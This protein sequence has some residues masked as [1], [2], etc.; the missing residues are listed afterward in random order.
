MQQS[1]SRSANPG[2]FRRALLPYMLILPV[3]AWLVALT[4]FPFVK[5]LQYSFLGWVLTRPWHKPFVGFQN[6]ASVL[7]PRNNIFWNAMANTGLFVAGALSVELVLG[8]WLASLVSRPIKAQKFFVTT[9]L[10]PMVISP[11]VAG[12]FYRAAF[13]PE[14]GLIN[15]FIKAIGLVHLAPQEGFLGN[16]RTALLA[17]ISVDIWQWTP[18]TFLILFA[19]IRSLPNEPFEAAEIDGSS[20]MQRF[21]Y[22]TLPLL[23]PALLVVILFRAM[24]AYRIFDVI[25][26]M[27][28]GGPGKATEV[29]SVLIYKTAFFYWDIGIST[30]MS[31]V[32]LLI[33]I[34]SSTMLIRALHRETT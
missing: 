26:I 4:I 28:K 5:T 34:A 13:A 8:L 20:R 29:L 33:A 18:F 31:Y 16:P 9:L 21:L 6:Y 1:Q 3:M 11:V 2:R 19:G 23:R 14:F 25:W 22:V 24:D 12:L 15:Y 27:T 10:I 17:A 30:A 32:M 7:S